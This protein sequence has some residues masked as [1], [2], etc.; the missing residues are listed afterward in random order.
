MWNKQTMESHLDL[1]K[2]L[3]SENEVLIAEV[4]RLK[5]ELEG[6]RQQNARGDL[7]VPSQPSTSSSIDNLCDRTR[8]LVV[9]ERE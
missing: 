8:Y 1:E 9:S 7:E 5:D 6:N 2:K 4:A 3:R